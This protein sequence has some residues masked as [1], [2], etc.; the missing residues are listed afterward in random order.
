MTK[1]MLMSVPNMSVP[2]GEGDGFLQRLDS[3]TKKPQNHYSSQPGLF[4]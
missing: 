4:N 1:F 2:P 3:V